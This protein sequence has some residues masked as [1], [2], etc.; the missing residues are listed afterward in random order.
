MKIEEL[1]KKN[2]FFLKKK[3]FLKRA[4][5][6][7]VCEDIHSWTFHNKQNHLQSFSHLFYLPVFK[8]KSQI[9]FS[10]YLKPPGI[11]AHWPNSLPCQSLSFHFSSHWIFSHSLSLS[12]EKEIQIHLV[13]FPP[14]KIK[15]KNNQ[16]STWWWQLPFIIHD[17]L[18]HICYDLHSTSM[19]PTPTN[20]CI[21]TIKASTITKIS[22][23]I[24]SICSK[25]HMV[26]SFPQQR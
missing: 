24:I 14:C 18:D 10:I 21:K 22:F 2:D 23:L 15:T 26:L 20:Q 3:L 7:V 9:P 16:C 25:I 11:L 17:W 4:F 19:G 12:P 13:S 8:E 6:S 5:I 1:K